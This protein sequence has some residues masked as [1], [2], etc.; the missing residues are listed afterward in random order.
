MKL[1]Q[2]PRGSESLLSRHS[3]KISGTLSCFD[4]VV[5]FGTFT[6]ICHPK[7]MSW[8]LKENDIRLLDYEK[9]FANDLRLEIRDHI[10]GV[11]EQEG[12]K[13]QFVTNKQ[14]KERVVADILA[15]RGGSRTPGVVCVLEAMESCSCYKVTK[16]KTTNYLQLSWGPGKCLHYYIYF[17]D[18]EYGLCYLRI[19]TWAPFRLQFYFNGHDWLENKMRKAGIRF[20]KLDNCY[21]SISDITAAQEIVEGIDAKELHATLSRYAQRFVSVYMRWGAGLHWSVWQAEWATDI[22]FSDDDLCRSLYR[23]IQKTA[24]FEVQGNDIYRFMGKQLTTRSSEEVS[25][26]LKTTVE[27]TRVKHTLGSLSIKMYDKYNRVIRIETT[28]NDVTVFKHYREVK[29]RDGSSEMKYASMLKSIY[30]LGALA[31]CMHA[32]NCRYISAISQWHDHTAG[33][34]NLHS[35]CTSTHDENNRS[36][37]GLNFFV[38]MDKTFV[39]VLLD[40]G[41]M[42]KGITN[43][44]LQ[45]R[46]LSW[47]SQKIGRMLRR[48][49]VLKLIKKVKGTHSYY[50][51][52]LGKKVL[53][54]GLQLRSRVIVPALQA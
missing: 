1:Q 24:V 31:E 3:N 28:T 49:R 21:S 29:H 33:K 16:N 13:P 26:L 43:R 35:V 45:K 40:G 53:V 5:L 37:R 27:G 18:E 19:P 22:I 8:Q 48:F 2:L 51:S 32:C 47:S 4:R 20:E 7:A 30:S 44:V 6:P 9:T 41:F 17:I 12:I 38:P 54:A 46:L 42:L 36:F 52:E 50:L 25:S 34:V 11:C 15:E 23:E 39:E 10:K 14:R